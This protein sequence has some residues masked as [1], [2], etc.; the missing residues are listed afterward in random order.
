MQV[1]EVVNE[2]RLQVVLYLVDGHLMADVGDFDVCE[3]LLGFVDR[4]VNPFVVLYPI[5]EVSGCFFW[6][7][8][9][10]Y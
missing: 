10:E 5:A 2:A 9:M 4:L 8:A 6:V 1:C 7:L 3:M